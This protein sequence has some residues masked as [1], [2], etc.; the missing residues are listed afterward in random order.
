ML[1]LTFKWPESSLALNYFT[2]LFENIW[3]VSLLVTVKVITL[4]GL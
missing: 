3:F 1:H 4:D 2:A